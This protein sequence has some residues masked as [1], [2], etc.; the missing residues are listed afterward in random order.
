MGGREVVFIANDVTVQSGSFGVPEDEIFY[1]ASKY[2]RENKMPR[3]YIACNS[4]ARIGLVEDLKPEFNIKFVDEA[5][6][7]KGFEY[8]Y[9][10]DDTYKSLPE[11]AVIANKCSEGWA[12]KD[13]IGTSEGIGVENLQGSGKIAGETSRAYNE[14]F[15]LS[16]VTGRSVGIGAYLVRLGQRIIQMKQG[17]MLLTGYGALNKLLGREVYT[18]QDQLGGPQVMYPNGV[19]HLT[20]ESDVEGVAEIMRWL[21]FVPRV[22]G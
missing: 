2:A 22:K 9:L 15:T 12:I 17:P 8:L 5:N 13:I 18:S 7:S 4:G 11:G 16:Y 14:I 6:P 10:D 20:V 19:S 21:S 3:V 1:K